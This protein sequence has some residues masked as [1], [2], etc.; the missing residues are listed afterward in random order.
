MADD[1]FFA[2]QLL[3]FE[4]AMDV[5]DIAVKEREI[6]LM[7]CDSI[8]F[9]DIYRKRGCPP[10]YR[11]YDFSKFQ[12]QPIVVLSTNSTLD[13]E[14]RPPTISELLADFEKA[15][16][17]ANNRTKKKHENRFFEMVLV[18]RCSA[19]ERFCSLNYHA[20]VSELIRRVRREKD[21]KALITLVELDTS[22]LAATFVAKIIRE[23]EIGNDSAFKRQLAE[24]LLIDQ[25][26][27]DGR[28]YAIRP[29]KAKKSDHKRG[30]NDQRRNR[31]AL[32]AALA[33]GL[34]GKTEE[35]IAEFFR[36]YD[37]SIGHAV[38]RKESDGF[39]S[40]ESKG[41]IHQALRTFDLNRQPAR[42]GRKKGRSTHSTASPSK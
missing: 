41:A 25:R 8:M 37:D 31:F 15:C 17:S 3:V 36:K 32:S 40:Y 34:N 30:Q 24:A 38:Q 29:V 10:Y 42:A 23:A 16:I 19:I 28:H 26:M 27:R 22:F 18:A 12:K 39:Y 5:Y 21:R 9:Q 20:G 2:Q 35:E 7:L 11:F 4:A 6:A 33:A 13:R 1:D 14:H